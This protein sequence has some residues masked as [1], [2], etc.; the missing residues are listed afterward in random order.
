MYPIFRKNW[1][2]LILD[3][4]SNVSF[5]TKLKIVKNQIIC[6]GCFVLIGAGLP[7]TATHPNDTTTH[8]NDRCYVTSKSG[9]AS[10][11]DKISM[12][13]VLYTFLRVL[14]RKGVWFVFVCLCIHANKL[15]TPRHRRLAR[16][17]KRN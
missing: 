8:P 6:T 4:N 1:V 12:Q 15:S 10:E 7:Y 13:H 2:S 16:R 5:K 17:Y 3:E 9:L 11:V 14:R